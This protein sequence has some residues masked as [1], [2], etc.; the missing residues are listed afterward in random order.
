LWGLNPETAPKYAHDWNRGLFESH[1][2][3]VKVSIQSKSISLVT[4]SVISKWHILNTS[5]SSAYT[6]VADGLE[7]NFDQ[8]GNYQI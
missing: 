8:W 4:Y 3:S 1:S 7:H 5:Q 6:S 2:S